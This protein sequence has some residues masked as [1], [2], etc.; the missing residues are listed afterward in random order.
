MAINYYFY[1][2]TS[3][4]EISTGRLRDGSQSRGKKTRFLVLISAEKTKTIDSILLE[5]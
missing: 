1:R 5:E 3:F 4:S 2:H